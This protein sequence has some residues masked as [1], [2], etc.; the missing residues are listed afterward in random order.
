MRDPYLYDDIPVLKNKLGI[1]DQ[2]LLDNAE[3]DYMI[4]WHACGK[5][6]LSE[7]EIPEPPLRFA[8]NLRMKWVFS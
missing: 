5:Y 7:K 2:I 3:A 6:I 4:L 1:R 8:A